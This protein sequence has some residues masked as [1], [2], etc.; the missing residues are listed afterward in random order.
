MRSSPVLYRVATLA[1]VGRRLLGDQL[2]GAWAWFDADC[3]KLQWF[4]QRVYGSYVDTW[5]RGWR[6]WAPALLL[7]PLVCVSMVVLG[8]LLATGRLLGVTVAG[9]T[10]LSLAVVT[11]APLVGVIWVCMSFAVADPQASSST[12]ADVCDPSYPGWCF[13]DDTDLDCPYG[14]GDPPYA[15]VSNLVV[16]GRD[17]H[18][19][20]GDHDG[21]GCER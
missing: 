20:D 7:A 10:L 9:A 12:G 3:R 16:R 14:S 8:A 11:A 5:R 1:T 2:R 21:I 15:P 18:N 4:T 13:D 19:L 6:W 17:V